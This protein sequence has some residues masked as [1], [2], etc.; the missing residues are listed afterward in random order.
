MKSLLSAVALAT[1]ALCAS[2]PASAAVVFSFSPATSHINVGETV[3]IEA[4][5]SGLGAEILS[6]FDLNFIYNPAVLDWT[7]IEYFGANLG[8]NIGLDATASV[9]GDLSVNDASLED[10]GDLEV[11][12]ADSF[13]L[14]RFTLV[15]SADGATTFTLGA[16]P[17]FVRNF[18]GLGSQSLAVN[19]GSAC[20]AVGTGNCTVPEPASYGLVGAALLAAGWAGRTRRRNPRAAA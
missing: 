15:G 8:N 5:M 16:D 6:A 3:Q 2:A 11:A 9:N 13:L 4:T 1:A 18:V 12:Q 19:V 20:I 10:D 14:F 7:L 17:L